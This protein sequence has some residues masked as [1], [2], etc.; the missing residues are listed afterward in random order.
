MSKAQKTRQKI[1]DAAQSML[2]E[3][4]LAKFRID[5]L[6]T[7]L[8]ITRQ[9]FYRYFKSKDELIKFIV[10]ERGKKLS[11][12]VFT[13]LVRQELPF[14]DFLAE[15]VIYSVEII[16]H[17]TNLKKIMG[18]DLQ[19]AISLMISNF[20]SMEEELYPIVEPFVLEAK[21]QKIVKPDVTT[22]D[23]MRW[24][25]RTF[26]SEMLLASLDPVE[27]RRAYLKKMMVPAICIE[28]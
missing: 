8:G 24:V 6:V 5:E 19:L 27:Q 25:F 21:T 18:D 13:E 15:G 26:L 20:T 10:I 14:R 4:G 12:E 11:H 3:T 22:R 2:Y 7:E 17:D 23:I 28:K 9:T 16:T 1:I